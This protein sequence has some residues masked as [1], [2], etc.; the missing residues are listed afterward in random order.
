MKHNDLLIS[1]ATLDTQDG[2]QKLKCKSTPS[3]SVLRH[4]IAKDTLCSSLKTECAREVSR[5]PLCRDDRSLLLKE[6][7][8]HN[9]LRLVVL[10]L[11]I[12]FFCHL[13]TS[14]A[15]TN[16]PYDT[17]TTTSMT[18]GEWQRFSTSF[19]GPFDTVTQLI[20]YAEDEV[21]FERYHKQAEEELRRYHEWFTIYDD[22]TSG[23]NL[24]TVNDRAGTPVVCPPE[25]LDLIELGIQDYDRSDGR[26]NIAMGAVLRLWHDTRVAANAAETEQE[27]MDVRLPSDAALREA[28]AHTDIK[29]VVVDREAG[30]VL[31]RDP[32]MSL[33]VGAIAKG[34]AAEQVTLHLKEAG[35]KSAILN[36]GGNVRTIGGN[37]ETGQ[38]WKV[39]I[40]DPEDMSGQSILGIVASTE[41]S[42]VTSGHYERFFVLEGHTYSHIVDPDTLYPAEYCDAVSIL[43]PDSATADLLS[44]ALMVLT[45]EEGRELLKKFPGCE[46]LWVDGDDITMTEGFS[47]VYEAKR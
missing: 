44:T 37:I 14:C 40:R 7:R 2:L 21:A 30:T 29:D 39:G 45:V 34:Y 15:P 26:V 22:P 41:L 25:I 24:K 8:V 12:V 4:H 23:V 10:L 9:G 17:V 27:K 36:V 16:P 33:D 3:T 13:V 5:S 32:L 43:A 6:M 1:Y 35:L 47:A 31:L 42:V 18:P 46:A 20:L 38:P 28:A 11:C 19:V